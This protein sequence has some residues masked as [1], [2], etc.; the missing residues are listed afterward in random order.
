VCELPGKAPLNRGLSWL[1]IAALLVGCAGPNPS[2][3]ER[4]PE[5]NQMNVLDQMLLAL[6]EAHAPIIA[7][8]EQF[9]PQILLTEIVNT[10]GR[11]TLRRHRFRVDAEYFFPAS[12]IKLMPAVAA[13]ELVSKG[14]TLAGAIEAPLRFDAILDGARAVVQDAV[15]HNPSNSPTGLITIAHDVWTLCIVSDNEAYNRLFELVGRNELSARLAEWGLTQ[16]RVV[17]RLS[18]RV[19]PPFQGASPR[20]E[21]GGEP[22][23][24]LAARN[25]DGPMPEVRITRPLVGEAVM[26]GN[27]R[28]EGP[29]DFS[30]HNAT[31][32]SDLQNLLIAVTRPDI[33]DPAV[34]VVNLDDERRTDLLR[35]M[36]A[37]PR[38]STNPVYDP[39]NYPDEYVK[40]LLPG[41]ARVIPKERV[42]IVN[43]VGLAYGFLTEN[44][45][46]EDVATGRGFFLAAT[47]YV[48]SDR[49]LNDDAYDYDTVGLPF[50]EALGEAAARLLL[51]DPSS[52]QDR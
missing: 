48:N 50:L 32:L 33:R 27:A 42:R 23:V 30:S 8:A 26:R 51:G 39:A 1:L 24:V 18:R 13:M 7:D 11:P 49:V 6:P 35:A 37:Y 9:R 28:V 45:Y 47:V 36:T 16:T 15:E 4:Q 31:S 52:R 19:P 38:E 10:D 22:P 12:S 43:K 17:H 14:G 44:A 5:R 25:G 20:I 21:I 40:F 41:V 34:P 46:I 29:L 2:R 3:S